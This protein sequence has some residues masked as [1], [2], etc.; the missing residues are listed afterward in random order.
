[1]TLNVNLEHEL[2][3][4]E[5]VG[6]PDG[7]ITTARIAIGSEQT[8]SVAVIVQERNTEAMITTAL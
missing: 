6:Y 7:N 2:C 4:T 5:F 8:K 1:M 3:I